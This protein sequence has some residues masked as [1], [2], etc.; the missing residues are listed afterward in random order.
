MNEQQMKSFI[1]IAKHKSIF[2]AAEELNISQ[3]G[4]SRIISV[5]EDELGVKLFTRTTGGVELTD[6][7]SMILPVVASMLKSHDEYM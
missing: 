2:R 7:G 3:Q 6:L 1:G 4:L 5:I